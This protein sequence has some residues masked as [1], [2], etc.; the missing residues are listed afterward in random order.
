MTTWFKIIPDGSIDYAIVNRATGETEA[1]IA[2]SSESGR[3]KYVRFVQDGAGN[4][5][6]AL[7]HRYFPSL[8]EV[9]HYYNLVNH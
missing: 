2:K 4:W 9:R 7:Y 6:P 3:E 5:E 8:K 1:I